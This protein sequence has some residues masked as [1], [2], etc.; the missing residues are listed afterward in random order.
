V[1]PAEA[2]VLAAYRGQWADFEAASRVFPVDPN[3]PTLAQHIAGTLLNQVRNQLSR[4]RS[5][6]QYIRG[7]SVDVSRARVAGVEPGAAATATVAD[8]E[9]DPSYLAN[10]LT[11]RAISRPSGVRNLVHATLQQVD[12]RWK[13]T[14]LKVLSTGCQSA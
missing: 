12:G 8:C 14:S 4:M 10:G 11:G 1:S 6:G 7:P 2:D 13:V 3:S 5:E 9:L